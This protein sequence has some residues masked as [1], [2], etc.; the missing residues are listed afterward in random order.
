MS[1]P[2]INKERFYAVKDWLEQFPA[3]S[4]FTKNE[5]A[6]LIDAGE[7]P[8]FKLGQ[9]YFIDIWAWE[10]WVNLRLNP[11]TTGPTAKTS[12]GNALLDSLTL[13]E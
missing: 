13:C 10:D 11:V 5:V 2:I 1:Q 7:L 12:T 3:P 8:G 4:R 6:S 9:R